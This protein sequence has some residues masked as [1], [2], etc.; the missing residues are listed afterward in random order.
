MADGRDFYDFDSLKTVEIIKS[1]ASALYGGGALGGVVSY[2]TKD[3]SDFLSQTPNPYY[4]GFKESFATENWSYAET[5][6]FAARTGPV[7]YLLLYTVV[8]ASRMKFRRR[9][10]PMAPAGLIR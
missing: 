2:A 6:T 9:F 7:D 4:F 3:P 10:L 1:S 8:T 5:F